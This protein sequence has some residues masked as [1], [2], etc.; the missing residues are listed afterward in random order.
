MI[1]LENNSIIMPKGIRFISESEYS[2]NDFQFPHILD[3]K[4]PG[5]GY[6]EYCITCNIPIILCS[7]RKIL[8]DNKEDQHNKIRDEQG[9]IIKIEDNV[10]YF[11]NELNLNSASSVELDSCPG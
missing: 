6:T 10:F 2:L 5:C 7:P 4:I 9:N 8:L 3:K 1:R 11:K